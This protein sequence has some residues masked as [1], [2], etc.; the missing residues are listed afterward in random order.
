M[1]S[2][3]I[4]S[5]HLDRLRRLGAQ[6][7]RSGG[8]AWIVGG[9][10]RDL[11]LGRVTGDVDLAVAGNAPELA[12]RFADDTGGSWIL[13]D[14]ATGTARIVWPDATPAQIKVMDFARLRA[15]TLEEDL[16]GRDFTINALALPLGQAGDWDGS[17]LLDPLGGRDDLEMHVLRACS[18]H[19]LRDDP[20]RM[21]RAARLAAQL[22]LQLADQLDEAL[23]AHRALIA[24]VSAERVRDEMLKLLALP[25]AA[26]WVI[27]LD[28]VRLLTTIIPELEPARDCDQPLFHFLPVLG[29][30]LEAVVAAE[31][32]IAQ[33]YASVGISYPLTRLPEAAQTVPDL[34]AP[35]P[36]AG[37]VVE[38]LEQ[39]VDGVPRVALFKLAVLLHDVAKPQTKAP[40]PGGGVSFYDHQ[41]IGADVAYAVAQR[42]R[43]SR[44]GAEYI[45]LIVREHMRP[46]QLSDYGQELTNRARYRF[47]RDAGEAA[48]EVLLHSLCDYLAVKGPNIQAANWEEHVTWT[49]DML[50]SLRGEET[51]A[52]QEPLLRG[53]DLMRELGLRPGPVIGRLLERVREAHVTGEIQTREEALALARHA[54]AEG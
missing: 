45:R 44:G 40:K 35:F 43:M 52:K 23:R 30:L 14:E 51:V 50:D 1:S 46:G 41:T 49:V 24:N 53:D 5:E 22:D 27:Y 39:T 7:E 29:H 26:R 10:L 20:L 16:R 33:L 25:H 11:L 4:P 47:F 15:P 48:P 13:L 12:R 28:D 34:A 3:L 37:Q 18:S 9:Y 8:H 21:L 36:Q 38:R 42:M 17:D 2:R 32:L 54:A 31:W 6:I 19:A